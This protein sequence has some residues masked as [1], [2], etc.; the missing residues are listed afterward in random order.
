MSLSRVALAAKAMARC[1]SIDARV[2][3]YKRF[4]NPVSVLSIESAKVD[5]KLAP[6][7]VLVRMLAAS[8]SPSDLSQI[9]GFGGGAP[10]V[11][12]SEGV[13]VVEQVGSNVTGLSVSD[14][15]VPIKSGLGTWATHTV[16]PASALAR[17]PGSASSFPVEAA[18][19]AAPA[20]AICLV[21]AFAGLVAGDVIVQN[22]AASTVGQAVIVYAA[23]KG[24]KTINIMRPRDDW[25]H[26][27]NHLQS[28][29]GTLFVKDTFASS[30][31]FAGVIAD[32]PVPKLGLSSVG[33]DACTA[34]ADVLGPSAKLVVYGNMSNKPHAFSLDTL[35]SKG[36]SVH[37]FS[38]DRHV[39][40]ST[41]AARSALLSSSLALAKKVLL[42]TESFDE[43]EVALKRSME[44]G[45][46]KIVM[47][48]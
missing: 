46:R 8:I 22:N 45:E 39:A 36:V 15:V 38:L 21:D 37:G 41:P 42:A 19:L 20:C 34:V 43:F 7:S 30:H 18:A 16:A 6:G 14:L 5:S 3:S 1:A 33:G 27:V 48:M 11:G 10:G 35:V 2:V 4:G 40:S 24:I 32:L 25:E 29:G 23:S 44:A 9:G 28:L 31:E 17:I 12:G 47:K 13:G 26:I